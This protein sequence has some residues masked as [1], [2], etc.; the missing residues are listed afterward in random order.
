M[1]NNIIFNAQLYNSQRRILSIS[2]KLGPFVFRTYRDGKITVYYHPPKNERN[3]RQY[4]DD[5]EA[6][7][8]QLH[9]IAEQLDLSVTAINYVRQL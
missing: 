5:F 3:S 8:K 2:G 1:T 9:D 6:L 4:R 7:S